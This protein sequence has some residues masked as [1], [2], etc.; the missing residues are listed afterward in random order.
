MEWSHK[1]D[2][3]QKWGLGVQAAVQTIKPLHALAI[4]AHPSLAFDPMAHRDLA[5]G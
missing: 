3:D 2:R 1:G 5:E 4:F